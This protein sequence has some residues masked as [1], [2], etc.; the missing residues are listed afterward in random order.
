MAVN[1]MKRFLAE[2]TEYKTLSN[3]KRVAIVREGE[4]MQMD[5]EKLQIFKTELNLIKVITSIL[6][7]V[8]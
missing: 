3:G 8:I 4:I 1:E 2:E 5:L 7:M 6:E